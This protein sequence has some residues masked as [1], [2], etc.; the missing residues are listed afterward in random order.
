MSNTLSDTFRDFASGTSINGKSNMDDTFAPLGQ[1]VY[2]LDSGVNDHQAVSI[3]FADGTQGIFTTISVSGMSGR[4]M[5][6]HGTEG[7]REGVN[8]RVE[9]L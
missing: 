8:V 7:Y 4:D 5:M 2:H 3:R 9:L 1:C 6:L